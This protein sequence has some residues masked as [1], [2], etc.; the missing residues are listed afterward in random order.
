MNLSLLKFITAKNTEDDFQKLRSIHKESMFESVS[1]SIG[2]W[3]ESEQKKRLEKNFK[4]SFDTLRF[5]EFQGENVGTVNF[6]NKIDESGEF[7][8]IEQFYLLPS[9]QRKGIGS[10]IFNFELKLEEQNC[11]TRLSVL[12]NDL[13][14]QKFYFSHGFKEYREDEYQKFLRKVPQLAINKSCTNNNKAK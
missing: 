4:D 8:Y 1:K 5:I 7:N 14:V 12:K 6:R 2:V 11:E 9:F 10:Y 13:N 3:D